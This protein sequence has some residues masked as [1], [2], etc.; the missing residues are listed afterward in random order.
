MTSPVI[1][2]ACDLQL[3]LTHMPP[4]PSHPFSWTCSRFVPG[5]WQLVPAASIVISALPYIFYSPW[6]TWR[7]APLPA[8]RH[9]CAQTQKQKHAVT[10]PPHTHTH[11]VTTSSVNLKPQVY[12]RLTSHAGHFKLGL[13]LWTRQLC[14][15]KKTLSHFEQ[16]AK[17][18]SLI[19]KWRTTHREGECMRHGWW[20]HFDQKRGSRFL[21]LSPALIRVQLEGPLPASTVRCVAWTISG[22]KQINNKRRGRR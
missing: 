15:Q 11:C 14:R 9:K 1:Y 16:S 13:F 3:G 19:Q 4:P 8:D 20:T 2:L 6:T 7:Q 12:R 21:S 22:E 18:A 10:R 5:Q 17:I